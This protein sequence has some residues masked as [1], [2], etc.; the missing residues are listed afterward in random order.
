MAR[1][2]QKTPTSLWNY[3]V[4]FSFSPFLQDA[5]PRIFSKNMLAI[6][7]QKG[8]GFLTWLVF[9]WRKQSG[10][11]CSLDEKQEESAL[12]ISVTQQW[13]ECP[14]YVP[15]QV[16]CWQLYAIYILLVYIGQSRVLLPK[17]CKIML[18]NWLQTYVIKPN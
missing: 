7:F 2:N 14:N 3:L 9:I 11:I 18:A 6:I 17:A 13:S 1:V 12:V 16:I 8:Q 5:G 15:L 10:A 4:S